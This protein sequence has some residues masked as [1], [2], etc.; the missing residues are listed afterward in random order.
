MVCAGRATYGR[1]QVGHCVGFQKISSSAS[2]EYVVNDVLVAIHGKDQNS[3]P[4]TRMDLPRH[5]A[6]FESGSA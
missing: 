5:P 4:A 6:P 1:Q 3:F 2:K